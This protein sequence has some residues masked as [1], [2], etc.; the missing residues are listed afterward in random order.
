MIQPANRLSTVKEYYFSKKLKEIE[1]MRASGIKVLNL[2][3]GN[4]D[5]PPSENA[6]NKLKVTSSE[7]DNHGYQSYNGNKLLREAFANW[8]SNYYQADF[9]PESEVLPLI[10]SKEG[11]MHISMAFL[12]PG[13]GVLIPNPSY[14]A[15][16]SVANL[17]GAEVFEYNL[18]EETDWLPDFEELEK[19]DLSKVKIMW[20]N[21]PNMPT[22][23]LAKVD[24]LKKL[25]NFGLKHNILIC[26][27]NPYSFI[28]N[29]KP[30]SIFQVP[31]AKNIALELNSLS[32][33]H[34]MAGWRVGVLLGN[35][36]L[37]KYVLTVKSNVDSGMFLPLQLAAV[38]ALNSS[39][40][41]YD[42]L[43]E[44]YEK[45]RY[46]A[47]DI[48][49]KLN[50]KFSEEQSGMFVWSKIPESY[51]D[52]FEITDEILSKFGVFITPGKIFG[53]NGARYIRIS[54][55]SKENDLLEASER[56][57]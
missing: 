16:R 14:P 35:P 46:I 13:D 17:V 4:P 12:N 5:M 53:S 25:V 28:L 51:K 6:I 57:R 50:C 29:K 41:W 9:D 21:Y 44:Q 18:T 43:N 24:E 20:V 32:K 56:I 47:Y 52:S 37:V 3:I 33:S 23:K 42:K 10:G 19:L 34:N 11:I 45:R 30:V 2:G 48:L 54:L 31:G 38:E 40:D 36:E 7:K 26:N 15:Y 1:K 27:D 55:A 22:G 39:P 8:Y 49:S